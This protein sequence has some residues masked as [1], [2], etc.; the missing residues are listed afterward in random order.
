[1]KTVGLSIGVAIL[2]VIVFIYYS[3]SA[4]FSVKRSVSWR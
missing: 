4:M 2:R 1:M 3:L